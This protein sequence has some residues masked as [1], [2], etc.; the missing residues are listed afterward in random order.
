LVASDWSICPAF[1]DDFAPLQPPVG[2]HHQ[3]TSRLERR[4]SHKVTVPSYFMHPQRL[5]DHSGIFPHERHRDMLREIACPIIVPTASSEA[6]SAAE[7]SG[8]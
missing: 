7:S 2:D 3:Q 6:K 1:R 5:S 8:K 4:F